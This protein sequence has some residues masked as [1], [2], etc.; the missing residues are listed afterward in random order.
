M[1]DLPV[2]NRDDRNEPV[3][4]RRAGRE[5]LSMYFVFEDH[6]AT[7]LCRMHD[8][9]VAAMKPDA[10]AVPGEGGHEIGAALNR[11]RPTGKVVAGFIN[12]ILGKG[13]E[14]VFA[15]NQSTETFQDDL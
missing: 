15:V 4:I 8:K 6:D 5:N 13:V 2:L 9:P 14:I 12:C 7:I 10:V 1:H 3:V 11:L